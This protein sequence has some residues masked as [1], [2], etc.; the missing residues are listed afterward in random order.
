MK[1]CICILTAVALCVSAAGCRVYSR[2][3]ILSVW[4]D[5]NTYEQAAFVVDEKDHLP[6][7]GAEVAHFNWMYGKRH[8]KPLHKPKRRDKNCEP[9]TFFGMPLLPS[10]RVVNEGEPSP[11]A[12]VM[13]AETSPPIETLPLK[14]AD[15]ETKGSVQAP[16]ANN[17]LQPFE[18]IGHEEPADRESGENGEFTFDFYP[19]SDLNSLDGSQRR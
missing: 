7:R 9:M 3:R 5:L 2:H 16:T 15:T 6:Y 14:P 18:P 1:S 10:S 13:P 19:P 17:W 4:A 12:A 8:Y 11:E